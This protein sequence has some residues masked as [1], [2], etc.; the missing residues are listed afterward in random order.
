MDAPNPL[1]ALSWP[2]RTRR[3][4]LRPVEAVDVEAVWAYRR[5]DEVGR[6]LAGHQGDLAAFTAWFGRPERRARTLV[7]EH[8]GRLVGDLMLRVEDGWAP[9]DL[10]D[11]AAGVQAELGW[12][13]DPAY[14]GRGLATEALEALLVICF[15]DLGLRRVAA[16]CYAAN[17]ASWRLMERVG[18]RREAHRVADSLHR[19]LGWVDSYDYAL[20]AHEW[21]AARAVAPSISGADQPAATTS[22]A[23]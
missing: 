15:D 9:T 22:P 19:D 2:H 23:G 7:V 18:M 6:W 5:R 20:L 3:L 16:N 14:G 8:E 1:A 12:V 4:L 11:A 10:A 21:R 17:E 13:L